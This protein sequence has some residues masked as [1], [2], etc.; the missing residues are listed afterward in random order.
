MP[1]RHTTRTGPTTTSCPSC[2]V[3]VGSE[4]SY[5]GRSAA[6]RRR[7]QRRQM[8]RTKY[9]TCRGSIRSRGEL[10]QSLSKAVLAGLVAIQG[11]I[12][13]CDCFRYYYVS[14][15]S[16]PEFRVLRREASPF[17]GR[18]WDQREFTLGSWVFPSVP[19]WYEATRRTYLLRAHPRTSGNGD[20]ADGEPRL[21]G[22]FG[23]GS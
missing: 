21:P 5:D 23:M 20:L 13:G 17:Y 11:M 16:Q 8:E 10:R 19:T 12:L 1:R 2:K 15:E 7:S 9:R 14:F 18:P 22:R 4:G 6:D 3:P